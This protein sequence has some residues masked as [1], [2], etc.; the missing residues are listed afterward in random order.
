M[1]DSGR[2][3]KVTQ[4]LAVTQGPCRRS[5]P[6][7]PRPRVAVLIDP[8]RELVEQTR[9][10]RHEA[11][12]ILVRRHQAVAYRVALRIVGPDDADDVTQ[13]AFL[14]AFHRIGRFRSEGTFRAWLL[15]IVRN[16]AL[17]AVEAR[18]TEPHESI[19]QLVEDRPPAGERTPVDQLEGR[20][21]RERLE[22]KVRLL[23]P[24]HR[25]VLVLRDVEGLSYQEVATVTEAPLG[26]VKG[27]LHRA[28][29]ELIRI[30]RENTY[31]WGLPD[32]P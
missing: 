29:S 7:E 22:A 23:P 24:A 25:A 31:D 30:L 27:R 3:W 6:C 16:T 5:Q 19:A 20:E 13:D 1:G 17:N 18:R 8:D 15:Q 14:R 21:R 28:R 12:E 10:G 32:D 4:R 11:F 2:R 9:A 26:S